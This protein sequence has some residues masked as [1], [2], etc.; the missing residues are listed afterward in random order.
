VTLGDYWLSGAIRQGL[1]QPLEPQTWTHWGALNPIWPKLVTRNG[2]GSGDPQGQI[3]GAP[4]RWGATAIAYRQDILADRQLP[5]PTDW[6]DLWRPEFAGRLSLLDQPREVIGLTLKR[7]GQSYNAAD[8]SGVKD[9]DSELQALHRQTKVYS[10]NAYLQPLLL[11]HTWLA[12][13]WSSDL[14]AQVKRNSN[15]AMVY[16]RSGSALW[17][18]LWVRPA[19]SSAN[20][21]LNPWI[22]FWWDPA[23]AAQ[24]ATLSR[25]A[26]PAEPIGFVDPGW[27]QRSE[28]LAPLS[29][30]ASA[31][32]QALW[33]K[34]R[35]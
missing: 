12:V 15:L 16:P 31:D 32:Y 19:H 4:Y 28:F 25:S 20:P 35:Q 26:S 23:I 24:L 10:S 21:L 22:D 14:L 1:L 9:L 7:L 11:G 18:D 3:W 29:A 17:A 33:A 2:E 30:K 34:I 8:L 13:G 27:L 5:P 6:A